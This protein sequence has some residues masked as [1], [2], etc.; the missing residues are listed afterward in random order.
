MLAH[1]VSSLLRQR[2]IRILLAVTLLMRIAAWSV[3]W[4]GGRHTGQSPTS[5]YEIIASYMHDGKGY[6]CVSP[7]PDDFTYR[8]R[9]EA[10]PQP[11]AFMMPGYTFVLYASML[12]Q[13][14]THR[15]FALT[16]VQSLLACVIVMMIVAEAQRFMSSAAALCAGAVYALLP[17]FVLASCT[18]TSVVFVHAGV[19]LLFMMDRFFDVTSS[20]SDRG[21][22]KPCIVLC[23]SAALLSAMRAESLLFLGVLAL[24]ALVRRNRRAAGALALGAALVL[25]PWTMRSAMVFHRFVPLTTSGGVNLYRGHNPHEVGTWSDESLRAQLR[26]LPFDKSIECRIDSVHR[27]AAWTTIAQDPVRALTRA[28]DKVFSLLTIDRL[29]ARSM[30]PVYLLQSIV[31]LLLSAAGYVLMRRSG[32]APPTVI[33]T[34]VICTIITTAVFFCLPRYQT[35]LRIAF[36]PYAGYAAYHVVSILSRRTSTS[37]R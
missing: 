15:S 28:S 25:V 31:F 17:E 32:H 13:D 30:H 29:D 5:E 1:D 2:S 20:F 9:P 16:L 7:T 22:W 36:V 34:Y 33:R 21:S 23:A 8:Y 14:A 11:S 18:A 35:M 37:D 26:A 19:A 6:S 3:M 10:T 4:E 12:L 24:I 27:V